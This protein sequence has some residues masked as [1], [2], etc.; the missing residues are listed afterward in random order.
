MSLD[1]YDAYG[2]F[3][4]VGSSLEFLLLSNSALLIWRV[5]TLSSAEKA[6]QNPEGGK[7]RKEEEIEPV[8]SIL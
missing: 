6:S 7:E 2:R 3:G 4:V 8:Y 5:S 1:G